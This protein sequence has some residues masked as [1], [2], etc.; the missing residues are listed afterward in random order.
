MAISTNGLQLARIAGAVFN[1]QLSASDYSE[2]L[3]ANKTAAELDAWAN[4]AV[5]AEFRN[6]T[7]TDIAKAVLANVGLS[8][9]AGLEAWVAGQLTAGGGV[10]KAGATMLAM[11]NDFSNMTAD[12]TYGA[13]ATTFNQKAANSQ[14][15]SQTAG[16]AG[17][18][19][20]NV[21]TA[22][23]STPVTLTTGVDLKTT[24]AGADTFTSVNP[25]A[26]T[27]TLTAGDNLN[28]GAG[29]DTLAI[30]SAA[31]M[32][33]G[34]GV[35]TTDIENVTVSASGGTLTLDTAL[36]TGITS[37]ANNGS[38]AAVSVSGLKALV[39]V[40]VTATSANT[41]VGFASAVT[42]G[43]ADAITVNINGVG[44][45]VIRAD[46]FETI[47]VASSG[48]A[49]GGSSSSVNGTTVA[50][51]TLNTL[52]VT[53]TAAAKLVANLAGASAAVTGTVTSDDSGHDLDISGRALTDKLSVTMAGGND[54]VRVSTVAATHTIAGGEGT[55]TLRY[56]GTDT[57]ALAATANVTGIET[58]TLTGPASF[59]MTG[60]GVTTVN[61][62][63]AASGTFGGLSTGGTI[64]LNVGGSM[65]A[66]A[67]GAAATAT[68]AATLTAATYSGTA[69]SLTVNVGLATQT[70]NPGAT[71]STVS[72]VGVESVTFNSLAGSGVTEARTV[73]FADTTATTAAL[74]S[75]TVTSSIPALTT[76]AVTNSGTSALTT[77]NLSGVTGGA[78][79]SGG[80]ATGASITGGVG[81]DALTGGAG[82]DTIDAGAGTNT[83]T[84][85]EGT[86]NMTGGSGV[87]RF[88]FASNATTA[89]TPIR[90]STSSAPD[91]INGFT[92]TVDKISITGTNAPTKYIG[93]FATIQAALSAQAASAQAYGASFI[94][95][96]S[97][98]YVFQ[99]TDG[100][101][102]VNDMTIKLPGVTAFAEGDLL[103]GAQGTGAIVTMTAAG[104][105]AGQT[106][107]TSG[108]SVAGVASTTAN[109][110]TGNDTVNST[111]AF[112]IG[113]TATAGVGSDTLALSITSTAAN[114][115]EGR[116]TTANLAAVTGFDIITLANFAN[117]TGIANVYNIDI[118]DAN[119]DVNTTLTVTSSMAGL[120]A[121]GTLS[122]AGVTFNA[123]ALTGNRKVSITGNSA[124]DVLI[125][126]AGNDT[127]VGGAGNDSITGGTGI[128]SLNGG[129]GNDTI[130]LN[131]A[132]ASTAANT[133]SGGTAA[134]GVADTLQ[135][136]AGNA[137]LVVD[138]T[139]STISNIEN[140]DMATSTGVNNATMTGAQYA[141]FT[142]TVSGNGTDDVITL[143]T[144]PAA[145]ISAGTSVNNFNIVEGTTI[146]MGATPTTVNV[147][148]TGSVG[149]VS[150]VTLGAATYTGKLGGFDTTDKLVL[151]TGSDIKGL[152]NT[153]D[154]TGGTLNFGEVTITGSVTMTEAQH[155]GLIAVSATAA[156]LAPGATDQITIAGGDLASIVLDADIETYVLGEDTTTN[157][158]EVTLAAGNQSA[159][160][161]NNGATDDA[162]TFVV[163]GLTLTA[164]SNLTA[165]GDGADKVT[166]TNGANIS[167][168]TFTDV[169]TLSIANNA[170]VTLS[171][172][173]HETFQAGTTVAGATETL[174]IIGT[175][176]ITAE[177]VIENYTLSS[178]GNAITV[179]GGASQTVVG[180][181]GADTVISTLAT[182]TK[183]LTINFGVDTASD[184]L[185]IT[186]AT[187]AEKVNVA[188]VTNFDVARD[189][190]KIVES[191]TAAATVTGLGYGVVVAGENTSI[192]A[193]ATGA[194]IEI[195]GSNVA[196]LQAT[197]N[198]SVI[199]QLILEAIG[200]SGGDAQKHTVIIYS[201]SDAG[202][203][204]ML[205]D[206]AAANGMT[207][208]DEFSI[209]LIAILTGVGANN[210]SAINF[211]G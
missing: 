125:G 210:L 204:T 145:A 138:L 207:A 175:G 189:A 180:G 115:A 132:I 96:E 101:M 5:A 114:G 160:Q 70:A 184:R 111:A 76:V 25:T 75:I 28:G 191:T 46:G 1:Q 31:E 140:L 164:A 150:T 77:V 19:Y 195:T 133:L 199:E 106:G 200:A 154:A 143:T 174:I 41:T 24:G 71:A 91:T 57:V 113:S 78:S 43:T 166:V 108:T 173:Q 42:A 171:Q 9:V 94:T 139:G 109:L 21:S 163:G 169:P 192:A 151:P 48:S 121:D 80:A 148:E 2:I 167:A 183:N 34:A 69:D 29:S 90:I 65:T 56:S 11:L 66:A 156:I 182:D 36:M 62:T 201:G 193:L 89:A 188:T 112:L 86:D 32:T 23:P 26:A 67:A 177:D 92:T 152:I 158:I 63:T 100:T 102:H 61:Y 202:I 135:I 6:K 119:V 47:N 194:V 107:A 209:E 172:A 51:T 208:V 122:T 136:G 88:E 74:K 4:A 149:T 83:I 130:I 54:A 64:G 87:D 37:V 30:T 116:L 181:A 179:T 95:G 211:Y 98:L 20:A 162:I 45:S 117:S 126:G 81:N 39:P 97:T 157:A 118:A 141:A 10:A 137:G 38:T 170:S 178:L 49:S 18:T 82:N 196:T 159:T 15:L 85:G 79:F 84:G 205:Y 187:L 186:N 27:T 99:N 104:A 185:Q 146:T 127:I 128:N 131:G 52:N 153:A 68:A 53:G 22:V 17:G 161:T 103:L 203:Y 142:G 110:T 7:T 35:T 198:N 59:A 60:A 105:V 14:A 33:L 129:D 8:S 120:L 206:D 123:G 12:A 73:T 176:A 93:T 44:T 50:S 147:T 124:H 168:A 16:T 190:M 72:A 155:D 3:A 40:S 134:Q 144:A 55:D 13:A 58:V 197:A 165:A